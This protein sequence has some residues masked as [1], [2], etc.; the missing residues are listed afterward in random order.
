[1]WISL[2][3][4]GCLWH[5]LKSNLR[6]SLFNLSGSVINGYFTVTWDF[7]ER[8]SL[9]VAVENDISPVL[10][11]PWS[12]NLLDFPHILQKNKIPTTRRRTKCQKGGSEKQLENQMILPKVRR[13]NSKK[14]TGNKTRSSDKELFFFD[15]LADYDEFGC[16]KVPF[17]FQGKDSYFSFPHHYQGGVDFKWKYIFPDNSIAMDWWWENGWTQSEYI[18]LAIHIIQQ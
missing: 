1:M 7:V 2:L 4:S 3:N 9:N 17:L 10:P 12:I 8:K 11:A 6:Y 13:K 16:L 14:K 15:L 18:F 5:Q